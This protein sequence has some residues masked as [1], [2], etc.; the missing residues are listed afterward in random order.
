MKSRL[1]SLRLGLK[2]AAALSFDVGALQI[3]GRETVEM[4]VV[5]LESVRAIGEL[6]YVPDLI[7]SHAAA[8]SADDLQR[9]D[10]SLSG[11]GVATESSPR[12]IASQ[13]VSRRRNSSGMSGLPRRAVRVSVNAST[14]RP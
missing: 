6:H 14:R 5:P 12:R 8:D 11:Q 1:D 4:D 7:A 3:P 10:R 2:G 9:L 13:A